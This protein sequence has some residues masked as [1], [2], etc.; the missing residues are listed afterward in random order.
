M[1]YF[2]TRGDSKRLDFVD[3]LTSGTAKDGG[4]YM[5]ENFPEFSEDEINSFK[6]LTYQELASNILFP[7]I[8]GFLTKN[9]FEKLVK[10]AYDSFSIPEVIRLNETENRGFILELF[11]GPTYAFKDI[12]MQLLA[13]LLDKAAEKTDQKIIV[14]GATSGDT[15]SAAIEACKNF[16]DINIDDIDNYINKTK[17]IVNYVCDNLI[18]C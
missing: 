1:K 14:L 9:D 5:P 18:A 16:K 13:A 17:T 11:H 3:V 15:G 4:L 10:E 7:Y 8:E 12:A 2:S 6:N